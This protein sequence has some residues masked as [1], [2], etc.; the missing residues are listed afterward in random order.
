MLVYFVEDDQSI[1]FI[2]NK[3]LE[4]IGL[5]RQGF[6]TGK[7]F[8]D[9]Y[10]LRRPDLI[11]LDV[12]LPDS[13]GI[14][15]LKTI[16]ETNKTI[17][18]I[19]V[20][21]LFSEMDKVHAL[22]AGADDYVTKP[23]GVLELSSRIQAKLRNVLSDELVL[24]NVKIDLKQYLVYINDQLISLTNKQFDILTFLFK[25]KYQVLNK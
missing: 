13:N 18:I 5:E 20:S 2:I 22:D 4:R 1:S 11:L 16:R 23:F 17:P 21:A 24:A 25:N 3:T 15:L 8:L 7:D 19:I 14:D 9:A 6:L 10:H 12:M